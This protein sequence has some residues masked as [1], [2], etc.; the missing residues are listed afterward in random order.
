MAIGPSAVQFGLLSYEWLT[1]SDDREAGVWFVN[2]KYDYDKIGR[3]KVLLPIN[4]NHYNFRKKKIHLGQTS[5]VGTMSKVKNLEIP[6]FIFQVK[7][8][9]LWLL[10]SILWFGG[11]I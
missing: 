11:F 10:W 7:W 1:K 3:H 5:L 9:L 6:Q 4:H 8:L 2:H